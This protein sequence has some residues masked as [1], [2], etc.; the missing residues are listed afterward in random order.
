MMKQFINTIQ[1]IRQV[2]DTKLLSLGSEEMKA[3]KSKELSKKLEEKR[4]HSGIIRSAKKLACR[5]KNFWRH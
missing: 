4:L 3:N 2:R 1:L 5:I